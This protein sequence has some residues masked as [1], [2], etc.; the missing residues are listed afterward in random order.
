MAR[1]LLAA[2]SSMSLHDDEPVDLPDSPSFRVFD[3]NAISL[4]GRLLNP[5]C[6]PMDKMIED[7][8]RVWRVYDRVRGIALSRDKFQFIFEREED[9]ETVLKDRP[10]SYNNWTMLVDRW[11]PSPPSDFLTTVDLWVR[12]SR[13]PMN[14]YK[15]DTMNWL[16]ERVGKVLEIAYDPKASQKETFIRALV[17]LNIANPAIA[18]KMVNLPSGGQVVIE[19]K[20][21]ELRKHCF[22][23]LR[24]T[25]ERP[26]CP[27]LRSRIPPSSA[28]KPQREPPIKIP[29]QSLQI[30][31]AR[32]DS[33]SARILR[34][35]QSIEQD[36]L[37]ASSKMPRISHDMDK[38]KG[39]VFGFERQSLAL[40]RG[41]TGSGKSIISDPSPNI[42]VKAL[43][44]LPND[45][46]GSSSSSPLGPTVFRMGYSSDNP[47][48]GVKNG[49][50]KSRRRPHKWKR[51][52]RNRSSITPLIPAAP[53]TIPLLSSSG[54][55]GDPTVGCES[56]LKRKALM[57]AGDH[58]SKSL[59]PSKPT[60][61]SA[62]KP[63]PSQ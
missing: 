15:I 60:V 58:S 1:N 17:R 6:Q 4:L 52:A 28:A 57:N 33:P 53:T 55:Q 27:F 2:I 7:M 22:H 62:L 20:Y 59:K 46:E 39:H 63:L 12:I 26:M 48:T 23:C 13:I 14:Y 40:R 19:Y 8:P 50:A 56:A 10:W 45:Q 31:P 21:E 36:R 44:S 3:E 30:V 9:L 41:N 29:E 38:G 24:L 18:S 11:I 54:D 16:A 42:S 32:V 25:H 35:N 34:V 51:Q 61:A 43:G 5:D 49:G 47:S 37:E